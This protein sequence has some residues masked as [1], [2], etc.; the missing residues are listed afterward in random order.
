VREIQRRYPPDPRG[1]SGPIQ[2][3]RTGRVVFVPELTDD[4]LRESTDDLEH[5]ELL[6]QVG[7]RSAMIVPLAVPGRVLGALTLITADSGRVLDDSDLA[8]AQDLAQRA[9]LALEN[10]RLYEQQ[11][12]IAHTLQTALLPDDLPVI[13][14]LTMAARFVPH[15]DGIEVGGDLYDVFP[16]PDGWA[17]AVGDVCGKGPAAA[18]L[19]A[20]VRY[21]LRAEVLHGRGPADALHQVNEAMLRHRTRAMATFCSLVH[22]SLTLVPQGIRVRLASAGHL[23]PLVLHADGTVQTLPAGG[24]VLG[25]YPDP[26]LPETEFLLAAGDTLLLYT[27]GVTE[28]RGPDSDYGLD[29]VTDLL[30]SCTGETADDIAEQL[31]RNVLTFQAGHP[32]DDIALLV[33][34][35]TPPSPPMPTGSASIGSSAPT[36]VPRSS[37]A[38]IRPVG[39]SP[40]RPRPTGESIFRRVCH[41][42]NVATEVR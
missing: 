17:I 8:F 39:P 27:D 13:P 40:L 7:M 10:A 19:T 24:T 18:G 4:M 21:T 36:S 37:D 2:V 15:G 16:S 35:A 14:G 41:Q 1:T 38:P 34:Q 32:R 20:L 6:R 31:T 3:A 30:H 25:I 42:E 11:R 29:R 23:P 22:G 12:Q 26:D 28:A 5:L 33:L 9:A